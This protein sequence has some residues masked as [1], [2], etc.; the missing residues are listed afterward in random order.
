MDAATDRSRARDNGDTVE[1]TRMPDDTQRSP[2]HGATGAARPALGDR[3]L[4]PSLELAA[5]LNHAAISPWS[6]PVVETITQV[7]RDFARQ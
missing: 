1:A 4:F 6:T 3:A 2:D 5:Y 7:T